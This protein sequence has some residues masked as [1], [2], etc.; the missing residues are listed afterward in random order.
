MRQRGRRLHSGST[1]SHSRSQ[2]AIVNR[3]VAARTPAPMLPR[4]S[5]PMANT[6]P[7]PLTADRTASLPLVGALVITPYRS[8]QS[9]TTAPAGRRPFSRAVARRS[10]PSG[11]V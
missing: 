2:L 8:T 1:C 6:L 10:R 11:A 4:T 7:A 3:R 9:G 5:A